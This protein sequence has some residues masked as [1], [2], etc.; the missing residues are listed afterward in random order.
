M[1]RSLPL[2]AAILIAGCATIPPPPE[3]PPPPLPATALAMD[4]GGP[5]QEAVVRVVD[6][7]GGLCTVTEVP[8]PRFMVYDAGHWQGGHCYRAVQEIVAD[9]PI[10]LLIVSHS[11]SDHLG[12]ATKILRD[13]QVR[14]IWTTGYPRHDTSSWKSFHRAIAREVR[15]EYASVVNLQSV[16]LEP[17]TE[18][19]LGPATVTMVAGWPRW[20][21]SGPTDSEKRNAISIV[22]RLDFRG[23]SVLFTGDTVGRR[24]NDPDTACKDAE[25]VMVDRHNDGTVSLDSDV[26]IAAHHGGNNGSSR[27]F[28]DAVSPTHV[29]FSAGHAHQHPTT[30]AAERYLAAG[31]PLDNIYRT[32]R[33]DHESGTYEWNH[34]RIEGCIDPR[35]DDDVEIRLR[36]DQT[37]SVAYLHTSSGC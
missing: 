5:P 20:T 8:G 11:D 1:H 32:D 6:V 24:L 13:F 36:G 35:G 31:V 7:G 16:H 10:D 14:Q 17:G 26:I 33:G 19:T 37:P 9:H 18:V 29:V 30:T 4:L 3:P 21:G 23:S 12:D 25:A 34:G 22:T 27:C 15:D 28:I 2:L